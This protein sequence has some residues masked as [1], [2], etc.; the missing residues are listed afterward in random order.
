MGGEQIAN[1]VFPGARVDLCQPA[2]DNGPGVQR[3][4]PR[5]LRLQAFRP[6]QKMSVLGDEEWHALRQRR[7]NAHTARLAH[8]LEQRFRYLH[9]ADF[10]ALRLHEHRAARIEFAQG[11]P[12]QAVEHFLRRLPVPGQIAQHRTAM[13]RQRFQ[14]QHLGTLRPERVQK[15]ALAAAGRRADDSKVEALRKLLKLLKHAAPVAL[16]AA[17][18]RGCIPAD[19]TQD[20]RHG[21]RAFAAAPAIDQR[22]PAR[23]ARGE[24]N[25]DVPCSVSGHQRGAHLARFECRNL[26]VHGADPRALFVAEHRAIHRARHMVDGKFSRRAHI[27]DFVEFVKLCQGDAAFVSHGWRNRN[28]GAVF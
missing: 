5:Q 24:M 11:V 19:F 27:D 6:G 21:S 26:L 20:Q 8:A 17:V 23:I 9:A 1:Q 15:P 14:V 13:A 22:P 10:S 2:L 12:D 28:E 25:L 16:I 3:G 4:E 18:Q 7:F